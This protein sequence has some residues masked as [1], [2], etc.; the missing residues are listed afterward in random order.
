MST[1]A[2]NQD[3]LLQHLKE[4]IFFL[5]ASSL[6]YDRGFI[7]EAKRLA[8]VIRVLLHDTSQSQSLLSQMNKKGIFFFDT[9]SHYEPRN[10]LAYS[11]LAIIAVGQETGSYIPRFSIPP[12][13]GLGSPKLL[14]FNEWWESIVVVDMNRNRFSRRDLVL[15]LC[16][17]DGGAHIDPKLDV[18]YAA[19]TRNASM[20]MIYKTP[21]T[22]GLVESIEFASV[23]QIAHEVLMSL[24]HA[25][26]DYFN[27]ADTAK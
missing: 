10:L 6:S 1:I 17:K 14:P 15:S 19:L 9:A 21:S 12:R 11:G 24:Q 2:Q 4:Q 3:D 8:V 5:Q 16:N 18:A 27:Q 26:P 7:S 25:F 23:R 13:P 20:G 22:S